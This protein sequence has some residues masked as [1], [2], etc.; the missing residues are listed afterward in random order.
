[1]ATIG[2]IN[3]GRIRKVTITEIEDNQVSSEHPSEI[4]DNNLF[5]P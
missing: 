1:M 2:T 3:G 4:F 5:L